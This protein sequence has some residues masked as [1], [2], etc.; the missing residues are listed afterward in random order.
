MDVACGQIF[1]QCVYILC[2][3]SPEAMAAAAVAREAFGMDQSQP[4]MPH[5]SLLYSDIDMETRQ[6]VVKEEVQR[7]YGDKSSYDTLVTDP[8]FEAASLSMWYTPVEDKSLKS[9]HKVA[10]FELS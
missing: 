4:Y 6:S 10:D 2:A 8:G 7:L 9:W 5:L 3:K 1:H